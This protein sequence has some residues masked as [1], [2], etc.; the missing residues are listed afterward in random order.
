MKVVCSYCH[1]TIREGDAEGPIS[2]GACRPCAAQSISA[3]DRGLDGY[4]DQFAFPVMVVHPEEGR[5]V[6]GN[7][8]M[9]RL[10]G[11][12]PSATDGMLGGLVLDCVNSR[13]PE[14]CGKTPHCGDCS[15]RTLIR[16]THEAGEPLVDEHVFIDHGGRTTRYRV[17]TRRLGEIVELRVLSTEVSEG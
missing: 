10:L 13:R 12:P 15:L 11:K 4:L 3:W 7:E 9:N 17:S 1:T 16:K 8:P 2:H 6:A 5:M 14:G